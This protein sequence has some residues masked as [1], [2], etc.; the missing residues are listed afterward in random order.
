M[1]NE[2]YLRSDL[3]IFYGKVKKTDYWFTWSNDFCEKFK[4]KKSFGKNTYYGY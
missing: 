3:S 2:K 1:A 4:R